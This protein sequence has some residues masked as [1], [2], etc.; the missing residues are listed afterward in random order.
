MLCVRWTAGTIGGPA[1]TMTRT[2]L[3]ERM[4]RLEEQKAR[5]ARDEAK[6]KADLSRQR[7]RRWVEAGTLVE[8]AGLLDLDDAALYGAL[9]SLAMDRDDP[10]RIA[11]WSRRGQLAFDHERGQ[12]ERG[13]EPLTVAFPAPLPTPFSTRL[14]AVGLRFNKRLQHWEGLA[15]RDAV[16]ALATEQNG[17]VKRIA[18]RST[19]RNEGHP[20]RSPNESGDIPSREGDHGMDKVAK[21]NR[22]RD[23]GNVAANGIKG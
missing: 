14:R 5:L 21:A 4:T 12:N 15:D 2:S 16:A 7:T 17:V 8:R 18:A 1:G 6:L 19:G 3:A 9:L 13:R 10:A 23:A 11:E 22:D 20:D